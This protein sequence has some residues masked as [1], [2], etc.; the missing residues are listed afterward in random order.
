V[1]LFRW[2]DLR[3]VEDFSHIVQFIESPDPAAIAKGMSVEERVVL[4][5]VNRKVAAEESLERVI[6]FLFE[7][8]RDICPC[9]RIGL[10]FVEEDGQRVVSEYAAANYEPLLLKEGYAEDVAG[11]TLK[12][13]IEMGV[14]RVIGDLEAYLAK[15]PASRSTKI[16]VKEG[17]RASMTCPLVVNG[18]NVGL[19]FRSSREKGV[20]GVHEVYL[21]L[22][23]AERLSQAVEK[24]WRI[25]Q[26]T[27]SNRVYFETLGFVTHELKSPLAAIV[28]NGKLLTDNVVGEMDP[29]QRDVV[30]KMIRK[31][32]L[33]LNLVREFLDFSNLESGDIE[34]SI[35]R[36]L[37]FRK[38]IVY[39]AVEM[40]EPQIAQRKSRL[41]IDV[42]DGLEVDCD[43]GLMNIVMVN[44]I[45][46]AVKYGN[47]GGIVRIEAAKEGGSLTVS[48]FNEGPGFTE[49][50]KDSLFKKFSRI[51]DA[52]LSRQQG[53]GLGLYTTWR[54]I[55][56][57]GGKIWAK[58]EKDKWAEFAFR[59]PQRS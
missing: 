41:E 44:L 50:Q 56:M 14:P 59:I 16:L 11:S 29:E 30:E 24:A 1:P 10:A 42:P 8:T 36:G 31:A 18:R 23:V 35:E 22:A 49:E 20:Y 54:L 17:V 25:K 52:Q 7:T 43:P 6:D 19:L 9:D 39:P 4:D 12:R 57:Q 53:T 26:L 45:G 28:M 21:H 33:L 5:E 34:L 2:G 55:N 38:K 58:S 15:K 48:V 13:V 46:N 3:V 32:E 51:K 47:D 37:D 27:E 40:L